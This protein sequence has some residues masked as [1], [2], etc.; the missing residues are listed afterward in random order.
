MH[1]GRLHYSHKSMER[2]GNFWE[3]VDNTKPERDKEAEEEEVREW[4]KA[5]EE[6]VREWRKAEVEERGWCKHLLS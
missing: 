1:T 6:E 3:M 5:E 2:G 4:R